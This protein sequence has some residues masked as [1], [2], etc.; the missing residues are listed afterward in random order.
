[1]GCALF[2]APLCAR[3]LQLTVLALTV[4]AAYRAIREHLQVKPNAHVAVEPPHS[5]D[6]QQVVSLPVRLRVPPIYP[7][8]GAREERLP[9]LLQ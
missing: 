6:A 2:S 3:M 7:Q 5:L 9:L 4:H 1:M 8:V